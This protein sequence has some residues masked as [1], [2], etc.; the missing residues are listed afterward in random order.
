MNLHGRHAVGMRWPEDALAEFAKVGSHTI[1]A[2]HNEW[3]S[4]SLL[5]WS[6]FG[7]TRDAGRRGRHGSTC[8]CTSLI[9]EHIAKLSVL[10]SSLFELAFEI[11]SML[12]RGHATVSLLGELALDTPARAFRAAGRVGS[13]TF[14]FTFA[15]RVAAG[16][17]AA[18]AVCPLVRREHSSRMV[19]G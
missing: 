6:D 10:L 5:A 17:F 4:I 11:L 13:I 12:H 19:P 14:D 8:T 18:L 3:A 15:T 1:E 9:A 16:I 7:R 2:V